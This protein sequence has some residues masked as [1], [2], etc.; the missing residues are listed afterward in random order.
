MKQKHKEERAL[1]VMCMIGGI[2]LYYL[3]ASYLYWDL[4]WLNRL[5]GYGSIERF[6]H[7]SGLAIFT[8]FLIAIVS[9]FYCWLKG[10]E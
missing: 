9:L 10:E 2:P 4:S 1:I 3:F 5:N 8:T 7:L 6:L